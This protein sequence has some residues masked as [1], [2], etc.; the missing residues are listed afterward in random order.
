MRPIDHDASAI[1][2]LQR[3]V[4]DL[5]IS[6][7]AWRSKRAEEISLDLAALVKVRDAVVQA[8]RE[9]DDE[10]YP[11]WASDKA[12]A[13]GKEPIGCSMCWPKDGSWPCVSRLI[14]T[15]LLHAL[16]DA[17]YAIPPRPLIPE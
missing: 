14:A 10:H 16:T 4:A 3:R 8:I 12:K 1:R 7:E 17:G 15:D 9:L 11:T 6:L 13:D 5:E 2:T